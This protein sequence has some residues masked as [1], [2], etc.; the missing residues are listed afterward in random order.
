MPTEIVLYVCPSNSTV[1]L[2]IPENIVDPI[3]IPYDVTIPFITQEIIK[4]LNA[5][6]GLLE[7]GSRY[8][9]KLTIHVPS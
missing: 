3:I 7:L 6:G 9:I 4:G 2:T 1:Y 5:S 8:I